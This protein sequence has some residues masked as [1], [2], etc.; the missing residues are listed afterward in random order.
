MSYVMLWYR[1]GPANYVGS[2]M[3]YVARG[4]SPALGR[5][6]SADTIVPGAGNSQAYNRYMYVLANPLGMID[7]SGHGACAGMSN[8]EFWDCRWYTAHGYRRDEQRHSWT[9]CLGCAAFEDVGILVDVLGEAGITIQGSRTWDAQKDNVREVNWGFSELSDAASG[10]VDFVRYVGGNSRFRSLI[11]GYA[12]F[13][14]V[15]RNS[16]NTENPCVCGLMFSPH[17]VEFTDGWARGDS[18]Y[19]RSTAVH[20]LAHVIALNTLLRT[21]G[22][23]AR[24]V[25]DVVP[26]TGK[27]V[28]DYAE[29]NTL[30]LEY[31]ADSVKGRVYLDSVKRAL[32]PNVA[33][34]ID[35]FLKGQG[36]R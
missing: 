33:E 28:S 3:D 24:R 15:G 35:G 29:E 30:N 16:I 34:W 22:Q 10:V 2:L 36:W 21:A 11:G 19:R 9:T 14:R 32:D 23:P 4:Y 20:E 5:F 13:K 26:H 8:Q 6:V 1:K 7:P 27:A 31:W 25:E 12:I 17:V 18:V